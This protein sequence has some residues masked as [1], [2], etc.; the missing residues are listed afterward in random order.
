VGSYGCVGGEMV[1]A[2]GG[3]A[4]GFLGLLLVAFLVMR[5]GLLS[6][7]GAAPLTVLVGVLG[8]GVGAVGAQAVH[9]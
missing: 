6:H 5:F 7:Q 9:R 1:R 4:G 3:A 2:L 8:G